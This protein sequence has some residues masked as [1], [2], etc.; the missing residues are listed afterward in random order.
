M[1]S[2]FTPRPGYQPPKYSY[3]GPPLTPPSGGS[4]GRNPAM[5]ET[6]KLSKRI[7]Q[8]ENEIIVLRTHLFNLKHE[9]PWHQMISWL[10]AGIG[11]GAMIFS[12][13]VT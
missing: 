2:Y 13:F 4:S 3:E 10:F 5:Q 7:D 8:L 9:T 11:I 1:F 6:E 12:V